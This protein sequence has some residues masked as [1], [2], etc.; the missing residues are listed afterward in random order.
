MN[1]LYFKISALVL[2]IFGFLSVFAGGSVILDLF[3]MR[4]KEGNY[5]L[6][7]VWANFISGFLY[8]VASFGFFKGK[9][10]T[11]AVL[12]T[13][14]WILIAAFAGLLIHIQTGGLFENK[15]I[16]V[17]IFRIAITIGLLAVA[18]KMNKQISQFKVRS[19][20]S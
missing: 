16:G 17:M 18:R 2:L 6:F 11:S 1:T 14:T 4:A 9:D 10:W 8:L 12:S 19:S 20:K 3:G 15:T 7:V 13:A 5:V